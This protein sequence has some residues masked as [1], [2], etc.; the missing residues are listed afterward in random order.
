MIEKLLPEKPDM[1]TQLARK[2]YAGE[3]WSA[4][5]GLLVDRAARLLE[6]LELPEDEQCYLR[7]SVLELKGAYPGAIENYDRAVTLR[8][9]EAAWRYDYAVLLMQQG[10]LDEAKQQARRGARL[11]PRSRKHKQLLEQIIE[12]GLSQGRN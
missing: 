9:N 1:L 12:A 10:R 4:L 3:E 7:G 2:Q 5:R 11:L 8:P 6:E